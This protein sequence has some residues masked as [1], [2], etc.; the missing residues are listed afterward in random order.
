MKAKLGHPE[1]AIPDFDEAI[2][3]NPNNVKAYA[4][5]G[6]ANRE[7]GHANN[8]KRDFQAALDLA[9]SVS[10]RTYRTWV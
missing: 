3:L 7:L 2:R 8:A 10:N 1:A 5:R 6:I 9:D 4:V